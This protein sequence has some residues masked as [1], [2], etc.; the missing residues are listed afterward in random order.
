MDSPTLTNEV[1]QNIF[2][3]L[4]NVVPERLHGDLD[5]IVLYGSCARGDYHDDSDVDVA[6]LTKCGRDGVKKYEDSIDEIAT[7]LA[8]RYL[9]I[10]NFVL[11][12]TEEFNQKKEWYPF[13]K[14][15]E[16]EGKTIYG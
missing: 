16:Q 5:R 13:F 12:P 2:F 9:A 14:S 7:D 6:L 10:V 3:D 8:M 15:I 4:T 11:I 1:I